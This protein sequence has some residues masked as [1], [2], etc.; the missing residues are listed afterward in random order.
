L[1]YR[2]FYEE[3][4]AIAS[5]QMR[6]ERRD[7]DQFDTFCDHMLVVD[8]DMRD[9]N[10]DPAVVGTYRLLRGEV[11]V[12]Q[13]RFNTAGEFHLSP[14]PPAGRSGLRYLEL[15]RSCVLKEYRTKPVTMQLLWRGIVLYVDRY[16]IDV[17][18][19]CGS[20]PGTDPEAL[21]LSL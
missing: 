8:K 12:A 11:A 7:F 20:L 9:E 18:L 16:N 19:G 3:M 17:M 15:G 1:R 21:K 6:A 14:I 5:P 2:V 4:D 10:G 13:G